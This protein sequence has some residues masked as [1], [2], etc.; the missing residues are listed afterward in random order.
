MTAC[1]IHGDELVGGKC[2][3]CVAW[4]APVP[5]PRR[6]V[7]RDGAAMESASRKAAAGRPT[8]IGST[9]ALS[10]P[11]AA[12]MSAMGKLGGPARAKALSKERLSEIGRMGC[13][14]RW[15]KR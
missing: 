3:T 6:R 13:A 9:A 5:R 15:G 4:D 8:R 14:A 2:P 1:H 12:R 11:D 7:V 10:L